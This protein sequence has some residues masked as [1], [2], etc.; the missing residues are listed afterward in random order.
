MST[1]QPLVTVVIPT[2]N[3][4]ELV[5]HTIAAALAQ[6]YQPLEVIVV[7]D[8]STD[9]TAERIGAGF[10]ARVTLLRQPNSGVE[11]ARQHGLQASRGAFVTFLDDDDLMHPD[12]IARQM[13]VFSARPDLGV[14]NCAYD[15][16]DQDGRFLEFSGRLPEGDVRPQLL[17]GC[18]PWSGGPLVRRECL[19]HI[20]PA[21][22]HD[23]FG[24]WGMWLRTAFAG[25][26]WGCVQQS[27]GGYRMLAG[28]MTDARVANVERLIMHVLDESYARF[29]VPPQAVADRARITAG[30]R[31]YIALRYYA[32]GHWGDG[33]RNLATALQLRPEWRAEPAEPAGIV[34]ADAISPRMRVRDPLGF[35]DGVFAHLPDAAV[36]AW[37]AW[38]ARAAA[39]AQLG[40]AL[41]DF[42]AGRAAEG[43]ARL[44]DAVAREPAL[45]RSTEA[46]TERV[47]AYA[48]SLPPDMRAS[49]VTA[50]TA[51]LLDGA[52]LSKA[53]AQL[54]VD[55][56]VEGAFGDWQDGRRATIPPKL[57]AAIRRRPSLLRNRGVVS[58]LVRSLP[59]YLGSGA[60]ARPGGAP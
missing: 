2:H 12:K 58:I 31:L 16:I 35:I 21:E 19:S 38:R 3:R 20:G 40:L 56:S 59:E 1:L 39:E 33:A 9:A 52:R 24:D 54:L 23:W 45:M 44:A 29:D 55:V 43:R 57:M 37:G 50:V 18:F 10:G 48:H 46:L 25:C 17:W 5:P 11:R 41:R 49:Y 60:R 42:A 8:G 53:Q 15:F 6:T 27:L 14:V 28:S 34:V 7:D 51:S 47:F 4:A 30:W 13:A 26:A 22:H 32:S 36:A